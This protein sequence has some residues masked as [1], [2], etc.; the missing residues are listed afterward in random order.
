MRPGHEVRTIAITSGKGGVGKT[1][2]VA[3]LAIAL[4]RLGK[5]VLVFDADLGLCN[6]DV[7]L[8]LTPK[9]NISDLLAG[10]MSLREVLIEGPE[11]MLIL[12]ASSGVEELTQ[13]NE[14]QRLRLL[15]EFDALN[16]N[17][18]FLLVD[19]SA[20]ISSNVT[21][22]CIAVQEKIVVVSPEPTSLTDAYALI[23][24]LHRKY[25][26]KE[27]S[28]LVNNVQGPEE[29]MGVFKTLQRATEQFLN[30]SLDYLGHI[31]VDKNIPRAVRAQKPVLLYNPKSSS[32]KA[33]EDIAKRLNNYNGVRPKSTIQFFFNSII[34][35]PEDAVQR[36]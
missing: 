9:Y 11:G 26:E 2:I 22:F 23:K 12:P 19:T 33:F 25:D 28:V 18:D 8:G 29:A 20:G 15:D 13:L 14:F 31:P 21:F 32:S 1:N 4:Q 35:N 17:I 36:V 5:K 27:F 30:L 6:I 24:V 34:R 3:N 10:K 7:L 16:M